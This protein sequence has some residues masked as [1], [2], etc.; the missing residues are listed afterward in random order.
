MKHLADR[1][2]NYP[3]SEATTMYTQATPA[4]GATYYSS[5]QALASG[6]LGSIQTIGGSNMSVGGTTIVGGN[7]IGGNLLG[8]PQ[9]ITQQGNT[10]LL[11]GQTMDGN[12]HPLT[13]TTRA[14]PATVRPLVV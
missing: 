1:R 14:S 5:G 9:L 11:Q 3:Y 13:H 8:G 12:G 7:I 4:G 2:A 10:Y 6:P